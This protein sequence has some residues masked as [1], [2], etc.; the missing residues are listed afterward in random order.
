VSEGIEIPSNE[1]KISYGHWDK[2]NAAEK[3]N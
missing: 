3:G 2:G 1:K